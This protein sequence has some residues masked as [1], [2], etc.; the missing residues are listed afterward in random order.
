MGGYGAEHIDQVFDKVYDPSKIIEQWFDRSHNAF[1]D[2]FVQYGVFGF[3]L[4]LALIGLFAVLALRLYRRE[5]FVLLNSGFLFSSSFLPTRCKTSSFLIRP[6]ALAV[7]CSLRIS[8]S[9]IVGRIGYLALRRMP[10]VVPWVAAVPIG[11]L[12]I[13]IV[14]LP[15][16]ANAMLTRG[17]L[18]HLIDVNRA[19]A[20]FE[21]GLAL[22]TY[23]DLE[24][25]YQ[26][27]N[28]Y[29]ERQAVQLGKRSH[30]GV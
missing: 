10:S 27:Y 22:G 30:R 20:Y 28:M 11:L 25:G 1:L 16:Y 5:P 19:N 23:A 7:V 2:Y 18:Y 8:H 17:Y 15:L 13:P 21:R 26:A 4:Y 29:T 6:S 14:I 9:Q 24:Y 12:I 3:A